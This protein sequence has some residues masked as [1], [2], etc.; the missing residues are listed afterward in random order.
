[1]KPR[2]LT[3]VCLA[4]L[5]SHLTAAPPEGKRYALVVGVGDYDSAHFA[6]LRYAEN[7]AEKVGEVLTAK[8]YSVRLLTTARGRKD[9]ADAPTA[10]NVRAAL[11][12]LVRGKGGRDLVLLALSGHGVQLA[13]NDPE[14][15]LPAKGYAYFCPSDASLADGVSYSTGRCGSL[16]GLNDT[17]AQLGRCGAGAKFVLADMCRKELKA[18][19]DVPEVVPPGVGVLF[20]CKRGETSFEVEKLKHGLFFHS[21]LQGL[22][23]EAKNRDGEV[24][25]DGLTAHVKR[26]V[27]RDARALVGGDARQVPHSSAVEGGDAVLLR[28]DAAGR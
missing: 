26:Q 13:V 24:T 15:K 18:V 28:A 14:D 19:A 11:A 10:R 3:A 25:W 4:A 23:G 22:R 20:S 9:A 6:G 1:M 2:L 16:V 8:G 5:L 27:A 17:L 12:E 21:V 7:D